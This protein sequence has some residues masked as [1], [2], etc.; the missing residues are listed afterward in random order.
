MTFLSLAKGDPASKALLQ[1]AIQARYGIRPPVLD[2]LRLDF[3][4]RVRVKLGP[5]TTWVPVQAS[6]RFRFPTAM[7]WDFTV[8]PAGV[9]VQRGVDSFDGTVYRRARGST[10][11]VIDDPQAVASIQSRLW[12]LAALMLTPL[13]EHFVEL[14]YTGDYTFNATN[15][16]A[17][18]AVSL[19]LRAD[20]MLEHL[21][22]NCRNP[23]SEK[24]QTFNMNVSVE[25]SPVN[26]L[27]LPRKISTF[28]DDIPYY[29]AEPVLAESNPQILD[30]VFTLEAD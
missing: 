24:R 28:W 27:M 9:A 7:R 12:I 20:H 16:R 22:V 29:E 13:T 4:G 3:N 30:S 11:N 25:Q 2:S 18:D 26:D 15:T 8:K 23:D 19:R 6:A 10:V 14:N 17:G 21:S 1:K 5:I